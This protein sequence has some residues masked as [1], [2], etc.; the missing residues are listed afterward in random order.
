MF[1]V[2]EQKSINVNIKF[3]NNVRLIYVRKI[4]LMTGMAQIKLNV[5]ATTLVSKVISTKNLEIPNL[6]KYSFTVL[7]NDNNFLN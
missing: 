3:G 4:C 7:N 6:S 5:L 1:S 2:K